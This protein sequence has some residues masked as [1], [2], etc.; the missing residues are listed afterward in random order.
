TASGT[1]VEEDTAPR[2]QTN[3]EVERFRR[4]LLDEWAY[5]R[6][7]NSETER[8]QAYTGFIHLDNH[9]RPHGSPGWATRQHPQGQPPR[10]AQVAATDLEPRSMSLDGERR[11]G[12]AHVQCPVWP[13][14]KFASSSWSSC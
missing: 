6:H 5:I 9:H 2:P 12:T 13:S 14:T 10:Q 8:H 1:T 3:D 7:W 11:A 4:I